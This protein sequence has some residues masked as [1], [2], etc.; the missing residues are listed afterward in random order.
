MFDKTSSLRGPELLSGTDDSILL[1]LQLVGTVE[2]DGAAT[3]EQVETERI[4]L[5]ESS[6]GDIVS[7]AGS[8]TSVAVDD[9]ER[10]QGE[11]SNRGKRAGDEGPH[12]EGDHTDG[13]KTLVAPVVRTVESISSGGLDSV[14]DSTGDVS[15]R[16]GD[17]SIVKELTLRRGHERPDSHRT[18]GGADLRAEKTQHFF[19]CSVVYLMV[20]GRGN[21]WR[22]CL[23]LIPLTL[24]AESLGPFDA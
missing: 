14:V 3:G 16:L 17:T 9:K 19:F 11:V 24:M 4:K 5:G 22:H 13:N 21:A 2:S 6:R 8:E 20:V 18:E 15:G 12:G 10:G 1:G 23:G 7:D